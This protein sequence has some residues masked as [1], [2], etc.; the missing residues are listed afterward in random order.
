MKNE[1]RSK[2]QSHR[3]PMRAITTAILVDGGF[4]RQRA[5]RLFGKKTPEDRANE[6]AKY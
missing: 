2:K 3:L 6:L 5:L 1:R 4:Y